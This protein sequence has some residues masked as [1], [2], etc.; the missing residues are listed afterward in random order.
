M[1]YIFKNVADETGS[2]YVQRWLMA[3]FMPLNTL[4]GVTFGMQG[5]MIDIIGEKEKKLKIV[6][7]IYGM[8]ESMFWTSWFAF[9][10]IIAALCISII[11]IF[12]LAIIPVLT[13]VNFFISFVILL[14]AYV[15]ALLLVTR[16]IM[17]QL[18]GVFWCCVYSFTTMCT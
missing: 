18:Q 4:L 2:K 10:V 1:F 13:T 11:Y 12:W 15:Q 17:R 3:A 8:T 14:S 7:N 5:A 9:Y 6:Q 16:V